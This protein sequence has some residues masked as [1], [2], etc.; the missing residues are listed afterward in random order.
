MVFIKPPKE[1]DHSQF[2]LVHPSKKT[3]LPCTKVETPSKSNVLESRLSFQQLSVPLRWTQPELLPAFIQTGD[4]LCHFWVSV[5]VG[6]LALLGH[7]VESIHVWL[8]GSHLLLEGLEKVEMMRNS[9]FN[10]VAKRQTNIISDNPQLCQDSICKPYPLLKVQT[11]WFTVIHNR[12]VLWQS[13]VSHSNPLHILTVLPSL[14]RCNAELAL[15]SGAHTWSIGAWIPD[16][17]FVAWKNTMQ[18]STTGMNTII[19]F[20]GN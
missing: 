20:I 16:K 8:L 12:I 13:W 6:G 17:S 2:L 9:N 5:R 1:V 3:L 10:M 15:K 18:L 7:L 19:I 14:K 4:F 11:Q